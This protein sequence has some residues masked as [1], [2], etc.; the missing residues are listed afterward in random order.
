VLARTGR[1]TLPLR[2]PALLRRAQATAVTLHYS[3]VSADAIRRA[4]ELGAAVY[5][6]TVDDPELAQRLVAAEADGIIT[7]DPRIF[8]S[9]TT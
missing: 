2:L 4:H 1:R 7:N 5:V 8:A 6:W 3:L 9:L